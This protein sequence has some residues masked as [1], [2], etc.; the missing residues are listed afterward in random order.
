MC[1]YLPVSRL[2]WCNYRLNVHISDPTTE[3]IYFG[4]KQ[5]GTQ[6]LYY[7]FRDPNGVQVT[8]TAPLLTVQPAVGTNGYINTYTEAINGPQI[9][10]M[11]PLGYKPLILYPTIA[12]DYYIEFASDAA[13]NTGA[14]SVNNGV[15]LEFVD[16][17]VYDLSNNVKN[18]R[19]WSNAWQIYDPIGDSQ[20]V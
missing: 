7:R 19:L 3:V 10:A 18:G 8:G 17:S 20:K 5:N 2:R 6:P 16:I 11:N 4:F 1:F 13:G 12:G 9:G 15:L 14:W